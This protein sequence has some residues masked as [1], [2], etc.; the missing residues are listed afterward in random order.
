MSEFKDCKEGTLVSLLTLLVCLFV[1]P[2]ICMKGW[3]AIAYNFN[4]P[5]FG[6]WHWFCIIRGIRYIL[7][8]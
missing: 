1:M 3:D 8:K 6:Y 4:L 7:G 5:V 2:F